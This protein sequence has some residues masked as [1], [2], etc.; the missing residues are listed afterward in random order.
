MIKMLGPKIVITDILCD[1][2][3]RH[4]VD[5]DPTLCMANKTSYLQISNNIFI[6]LRD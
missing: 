2:I 4:K 5:E 6:R 1:T 3:P